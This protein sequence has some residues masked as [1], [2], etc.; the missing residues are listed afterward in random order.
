M[1]DISVHFEILVR[2]LFQTT[3]LTTPAFLGWISADLTVR[4]WVHFNGFGWIWADVVDLNG[5]GWTLVDWN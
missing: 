1:D 4:I 2:S 3:L 5:F